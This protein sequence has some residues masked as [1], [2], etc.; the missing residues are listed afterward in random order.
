MVSFFKALSLPEMPRN[1]FI[2]LVGSN[3]YMDFVWLSS[4]CPSTKKDTAS[5]TSSTVFSLDILLF[6][7]ADNVKMS[8]LVSHIRNGCHGGNTLS[9]YSRLVRRSSD[10]RYIC[11]VSSL[12][13]I[14]VADANMVKRDFKQYFHKQSMT[15]LCLFFTC[16]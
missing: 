12:L 5:S 4:T 10:N 15:L 2:M 1:R 6:N 7:P 16:V 8:L 13:S 3:S 11:L 14:G 9:V